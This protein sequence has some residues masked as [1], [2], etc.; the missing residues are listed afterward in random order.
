MARFSRALYISILHLHKIRASLEQMQASLF[1]GLGNQTQAASA[2]ALSG[3]PEF[4][5]FKP[6]GCWCYFGGGDIARH[7]GR[8]LPLD[9]WDTLCK[10]LQEGYECAAID[11]EHFGQ[12]CEPWSVQYVNDERVALAAIFSPNPQ[13]PLA[14]ISDLCNRQND[15]DSCGITS[16]IL[17][18]TY[19]YRVLVYLLT[20]GLPDHM[21]IPQL[22]AQSTD[23]DFFIDNGFDRVS[24]CPSSGPGGPAPHKECCGQHPNRF[25]YRHDTMSRVCCETPGGLGTVFNP[26][27][28]ECCS[29]GTTGSIGSFC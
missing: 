1:S 21:S 23:P 29:D 15:G 10:Q 24:G 19:V 27:I 11:A 18:T 13:G 25:P 8:G 9:E 4:D 26:S 6:Y 14:F 20:R 12:T 16:C 17:E 2:R 22:A 28:H 7:Y 3:D 5:I